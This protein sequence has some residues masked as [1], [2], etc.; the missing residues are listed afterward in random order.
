MVPEFP[1]R[2]ARIGSILALLGSLIWVQW[3][4]DFA[5]FNVSAMLLALAAFV[6][7]AGIELSDYIGDNKSHDNV[8]S[9]DV[10]K[11]NSL[12]K[13]IDKN[14]FYI[15]KEKGIHT[16]GTAELGRVRGSLLMYA[17][18]KIQAVI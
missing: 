11:L 4:I 16:P 5:K 10:D 8:M 14:Q 7:W 15:L 9:D 13:I 1:R 3:P 2:I 12:L 17:A 18:D 6:T